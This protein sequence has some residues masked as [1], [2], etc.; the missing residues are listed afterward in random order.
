ATLRLAKLTGAD[1]RQTTFDGAV[2]EMA[3]AAG[4]DFSYS[5]WVGA[6]AKMALLSGCRLRHVDLSHADLEM[7][8]LSKADLTRANLHNVRDDKTIWL[9]A[10]KSGAKPTDADRLHEIG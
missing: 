6:R 5:R 3:A 7:A 10:D 2:L 9:G 4:C 1:L 8:D